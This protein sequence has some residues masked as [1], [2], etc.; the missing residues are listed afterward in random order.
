MEISKAI[1]QS[2]FPPLESWLL[3]IFHHSTVC[4][5]TLGREYC[6]DLVQVTCPP[7]SV[8]L[9]YLKKGGPDWSDKDTSPQ[10]ASSSGRGDIRRAFAGVSVAQALGQEVSWEWGKP[11]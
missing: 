1:Y 6:R 4:T 11:R 9:C 3:N 10:R 7:L 2:F 5:V 8:W